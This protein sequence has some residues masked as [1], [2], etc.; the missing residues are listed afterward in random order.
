M[1]PVVILRAARTRRADVFELGASPTSPDLAQHFA[2]GREI[3]LEGASHYIAM[4]SPDKV[5]EEI[6]TLL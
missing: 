2:N 1:H 6:Q 3:V 4:E 5:T